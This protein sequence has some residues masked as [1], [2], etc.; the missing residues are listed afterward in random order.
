MLF[1][2]LVNTHTHT[3]TYT[4]KH[5]H[6]HLLSHS[7]SLIAVIL[8]TFVASDRSWLKAGSLINECVF[9]KPGFSL[10]EPG[11]NNLSLCVHACVVLY[12]CECVFVYVRIKRPN[13]QCWIQLTIIWFSGPKAGVKNDLDC[14]SNEAVRYWESQCLFIIEQKSK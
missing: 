11:T 14:P 2:Y 5:T 4:H 7:L 9:G 6:T 13:R 1:S 3:L 8:S 10:L 12:V